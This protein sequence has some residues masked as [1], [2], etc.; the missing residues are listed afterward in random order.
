MGYGQEI[1]EM[2]TVQN[3]AMSAALLLRML[4]H[5]LHCVLHVYIFVHVKLLQ[6]SQRA[7]TL[8]VGTRF[9]IHTDIKLQCMGKPCH[10][11]CYLVRME[12]MQAIFHA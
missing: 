6:E 2:L 12:N 5:P 11:K 4:M 7:A 10:A 9:I 3:R 1:Q 8:G